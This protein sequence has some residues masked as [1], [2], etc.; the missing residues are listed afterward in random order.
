MLALSIFSQSPT[1]DID[2]CKMFTT[3]LPPPFRGRVG[4][5]VIKIITKSLLQNSIGS[6]IFTEAN[7]LFFLRSVFISTIISQVKK[8]KWTLISLSFLT[9]FLSSSALA[10][11][12]SL[13]GIAAIV[14]DKVITQGQL[15]KAMTIAQEQF[16]QANTPMPPLNVVRKKVLDHLIDTQLQLQMAKKMGIKVGNKQIDSTI[17]RIA[18]QNHLTIDQLKNTVTQTGM[19]YADYRKEISKQITISMVQQKAVAPRVVVSDQEVKDYLANPQTQASNNT[20]NTGSYHIQDI[21]I[22]LPDGASSQ[23]IEAAKQR[24]Q[25]IMALLRK[26][27]SVSDVVAQQSD[28]QLN[29]LGWHPFNELPDLFK[30]AVQT[31]QTGDVAGPIIAPNGVHIIKL[32]AVVKGGATASQEL[33]VETHVRHILIKTT[34]M[35]TD[36]KAKAKLEKLRAVILKDHDFARVAKENSQDPGSALK[37][38]D[39]GWTMPGTLDPVFTQQMDQLKPGQ[40]SEPFKSQFGW[41]I[42]QV[43]GRKDAKHNLAYLQQQAREAIYQRKFQSEVKVWM[44]NL[45]GQAYVK[46]MK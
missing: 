45:Q 24:A 32:E 37:G 18:Q 35:E 41:H 12:Q 15:N 11:S 43:L 40:I 10:D 20:P 21:M 27:T 34:P 30:S 29:H 23:Q 22:A 39:L 5:G 44:K 25:T 1:C 33:P 42:L 4:E 38:G 14:N 36:A 2:I 13:D 6:K 3:C 8:S 31:M 16:Q 26:G 28:L 9:F 46:I 7:M 17:S 19:S